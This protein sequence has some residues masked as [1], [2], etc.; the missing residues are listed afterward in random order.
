[1][2]FCFGQPVALGG[3]GGGNPKPAVDFFLPDG[4]TTTGWKQ[5]DEL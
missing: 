4:S 3:G 2:M 5:G 1:M